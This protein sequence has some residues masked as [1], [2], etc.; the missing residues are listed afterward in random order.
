M[1]LGLDRDT[2]IK[3]LQE[4][5]EVL[6]FQIYEYLKKVQT[7]HINTVSCNKLNEQDFHNLV[8]KTALVVLESLKERTSCQLPLN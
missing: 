7:Y 4:D 5:D 2:I 3:G 6:L 1:E 8:K